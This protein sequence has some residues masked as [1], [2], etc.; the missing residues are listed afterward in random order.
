MKTIF[1]NEKTKRSNNIKLMNEQ[2]ADREFKYIDDLKANSIHNITITEVVGVSLDDN[3]YYSNGACAYTVADV[4]GKTELL[5][6][7]SDMENGLM[8]EISSP[9]VNIMEQVEYDDNGEYDEEASEREWTED[10]YNMYAEEWLSVDIDLI[11]NNIVGETCI[12]LN[13]EYQAEPPLGVV[14]E[15]DMSTIKVLKFSGEMIDDDGSRRPITEEDFR[16]FTEKML[17]RDSTGPSIKHDTRPDAPY[18]VYGRDNH[19]LSEALKSCGWMDE[20]CAE[21]YEGAATVQIHNDEYYYSDGTE[22][23]MCGPLGIIS[24]PVKY[25]NRPSKK[26]A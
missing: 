3:G 2:Y 6:L 8:I 9:W 21:A 18:A 20:I 12:V 10:E 11:S 24:V 5:A 19:E 25:Y 13:G 16:F 26:A 22:R 23:V 7:Y 17:F 1:T 14:L 4:N 15:V